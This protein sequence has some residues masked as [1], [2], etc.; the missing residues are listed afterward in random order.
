MRTI[1]SQGLAAFE[2]PVWRGKLPGMMTAVAIA[3]AASFIAEHRGGPQLLYALL[4]GMAF[5]FAA[6]GPK[7]KEGIDFAGRQLL[8]IGI[9]LLGARITLAQVADLGPLVL[10]LVPGGMALTIVL[11]GWL[12]RRFGFTRAEG[13]WPAAPSPSAAP[14]PRWRCRR[15]CRARR[16]RSASRC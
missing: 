4:F 15:C 7:V 16:S 10:L 11:A 6:D 8:R 3:L 1:Y 2:S 5:N 9:A 13:C 14:R 12:G